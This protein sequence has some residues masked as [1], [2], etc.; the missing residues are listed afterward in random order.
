L[1][2]ILILESDMT[3]ASD[4]AFTLLGW[5]CRV[6]GIAQDHQSAMDYCE[7]KKIDLVITETK[8]DGEPD[9][10]EC[11]SILQDIYD[12]PVIFATSHVDSNTLNNAAKVDFSG[13][14][15]KPYKEDD[16]LVHIR[17]VIAKYHLLD[18]HDQDCCGYV[19]DTQLNKIY[20]DDTEI[21]L[22]THEKL[23]FLLL[24]QQRGSLITHEKIDEVIWND[25]FVSDETRRQ[26][27]HRLKAKLPHDSIE[28]VR[29]QGYRFK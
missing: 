4:L 10:I 2:D 6:A 11:A 21:V 28:I 1:I 25:E 13:Y 7:N 12:M 8:I 18:H 29:G 17:L 27:V 26:L 24:F 20:C 22:T 16:L 23:L 9:G 5:G 3:T 14:L 15:I 19:H